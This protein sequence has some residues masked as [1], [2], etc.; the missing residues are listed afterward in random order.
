M[1]RFL[2]SAV[3]ALLT[4]VAAFSANT[5]DEIRVTVTLAQ[6]GSALFQEVWNV[7]AESG[8]E[9]YV[10]R[11]DLREMQISDL[12]ITDETGRSF[13][14]LG[15]WDINASRKDKEGKCG[16]V[17]TSRGVEICWG[18]GDYGDHTFNVSYR[19]SNIVTAYTDYDAFHFQIVP[20]GIA[21]RKASVTLI[22]PQSLNEDNSRIWGF[23]FDGEIGYDEG[24]VVAKSNKRLGEYNSVIEL[25]RFDKGIFEP[26]VSR[27]YSFDVV[28]DRA[29]EGADF[30]EKDDVFGKIFAI[31]TTILFALAFALPLLFNVSA[32]ARRKR[33]KLFGMKDKDVP[34]NRDVPFDGD[35]VESFTVAEDLG[36]GDKNGNIA[37]AIIMRMIYKSVLWAQKD[38]DE[39][40]ILGFNCGEELTG[41]EWPDSAKR[42]YR[43]LYTASG[44]DHILQPNEFSNWAGINKQQFFNWSN[45]I[46]S[47]GRKRL[48][49]NSLASRSMWGTSLQYSD[50]GKDEAKKLYGFRRFLQEFTLIGERSTPEVSLWQDYMVFGALFGIADKVGKELK[51]INPTLYEQLVPMGSATVTTLDT[52]NLSNMLSRNIENARAA[53]QAALE[54]SARSAGGFGGHTSIGGGGGFS[55]GGHGGFR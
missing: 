23:G 13:T 38:A 40:I 35:I 5:V 54:R 24:V 8:T 10:S 48:N 44:E 21:P 50:K 17:N 20:E 16:I 2:L 37:S 32:N 25:I 45:D 27:D 26:R 36:F 12:A 55:G 41:D 30:S 18:F 15:R 51:E 47:D 1:R 39:K 49:T 19:I 46:G 4:A 22:A 33:K 31:F 34:W 43:L 42:L 11:E 53:Q 7:H 52:W 3:A 9:L 14:V 6:D 28:L 29:M